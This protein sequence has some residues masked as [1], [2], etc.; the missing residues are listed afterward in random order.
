M[1]ALSESQLIPEGGRRVVDLLEAFRVAQSQN[2]N[3]VALRVAM[4]LA[5]LPE[6]ERPENWT[7][8]ERSAKA[9]PPNRPLPGAHR[10]RVTLRHRSLQLTPRLRVCDAPVSHLD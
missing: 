3:L 7:T 9:V 8:S 1:R 6:R 2:S 10:G 5:R 4:D